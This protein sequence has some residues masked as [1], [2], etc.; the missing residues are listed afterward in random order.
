[1]Y[2]INPMYSR[3]EYNAD[4]NV[5]RFKVLN[6]ISTL[7]KVLMYP[8]DI[9]LL[10]VEYIFLLCILTSIQYTIGTWLMEKFAN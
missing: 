4:V 10:V 6:S 9:S 3:Y 7:K 8:L 1:M 5:E 2:P